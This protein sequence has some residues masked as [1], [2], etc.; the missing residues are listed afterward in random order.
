MCPCQITEN[1]FRMPDA[2]TDD[3]PL[4]SANHC[5]NR[6]HEY[7]AKAHAEWAD[8]IQSQLRGWLPMNAATHCAGASIDFAIHAAERAVVA[9][10]LH[11]RQAEFIAGRWCAH[12]A[13][14]QLGS[15]T[16]LIPVGA[17]GGPE[18]PVGIIGSITHDSGICLAIAMQASR[19]NGIGIDLFDTRRGVEMMEIANLVLG[20]EEMVAGNYSADSTS[21]LKLVFSAK[22]AVVK[23]VSKTMGR[24]LDMREIR[25]S[26]E[27]NTFRAGLESFP[28]EISGKWAYVGHFLL[29]LAILNVDEIRALTS[30]E[31]RRTASQRC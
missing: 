28:H 11:S 16:D 22:E 8:C 25:L 3:L 18:W 10:A 27:A 13:L 30:G 29:T 19:L 7:H 1:L 9:N 23:A 2:R 20:G 17:L 24:F 4:N 14:E 6:S 26:V 21:Y 12:R 5:V 15:S 31:R